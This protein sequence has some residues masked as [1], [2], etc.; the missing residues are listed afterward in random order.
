MCVSFYTLC[1]HIHTHIRRH[2]KIFIVGHIHTPVPSK[3]SA[4]KTI[5]R[6]VG[7]PTYEKSRVSYQSA[8]RDLGPVLCLILEES[9]AF[10]FDH[11][12][13]LPFN[14]VLRKL[15]RDPPHLRVSP[16][17]CKSSRVI[18]KLITVPHE[19]PRM[20][21]E[22]ELQSSLQSLMNRFGG[23]QY[24]NS[25]GAGCCEH[26]I[27]NLW[28]TGSSRYSRE[29]MRNKFVLKGYYYEMC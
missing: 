16:D 24:I 27:W 10:Q 23:P 13:R 14:Q 7:I 11:N 29:H 28:H 8:I 19:M 5:C 12:R 4:V 1:T 20:L 6:G 21:S 25:L 17:V 18:T 22:M 26:S 9:V 3:H 15:G 2:S